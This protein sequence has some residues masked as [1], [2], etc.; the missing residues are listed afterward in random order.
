MAGAEAA[1]AAPKIISTDLYKKIQWF[2]PKVAPIF[3]TIPIHSERT[4]QLYMLNKD[5]LDFE[6]DEPKTF[7]GM[8]YIALSKDERGKWKL[9]EW[10]SKDS[11]YTVPFEYH[12]ELLTFIEYMMTDSKYRMGQKPYIMEEEGDRDELKLVANFYCH[13]MDHDADQDRLYREITKEKNYNLKPIICSSKFLRDFILNDDKTIDECLENVKVLR[14]DLS[15]KTYCN[16]SK[17]FNSILDSILLY[18]MSVVKA[19]G[20]IDMIEKYS[21]LISYMLE[22]FNPK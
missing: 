2:G 16:G 1:P 12:K 8:S 14:T 10:S 11:C 22:T 21:R 13:R 17:E 4:I 7:Y 5:A 9:M 3:R 6:S 18:A 20:N 15:T 19:D